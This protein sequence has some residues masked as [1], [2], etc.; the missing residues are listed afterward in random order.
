MITEIVQLGIDKGHV[1][2]SKNNNK[3]TY[4]AAGKTYKYTPTHCQDKKLV[5]LRWIHRHWLG[6]L[7]R[8]EPEGRPECQ[9]QRCTPRRGFGSP[10]P[11]A[12]F[13]HYKTQNNGQDNTLPR[14]LSDSPAY[15]LPQL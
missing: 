14:P 7:E 9:R 3:I 8:R 4:E 2:L 10:M 6:P 1:S 13:R 5:V 12:I 11:G 15:K